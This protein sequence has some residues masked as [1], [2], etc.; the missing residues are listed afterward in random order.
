MYAKVPVRARVDRARGKFLDTGPLSAEFEGAKILI[1]RTV[2][3]FWL[4][5]HPKTKLIQI[6]EVDVAVVHAFDQMVTNG[7]RKP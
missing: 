2:R 4:R 6:I 3:H 5:F 7:G 1:L